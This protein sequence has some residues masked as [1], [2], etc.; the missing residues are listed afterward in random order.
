L[1]EACPTAREANIPVE[2][3]HLK[4]SGK[5]NGGQDEDVIAKIE[6]SAAQTDWT[7]LRTSIH[8]W[9]AQRRSVGFHSA[10]VA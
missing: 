10:E 3:F 6:Q 4:A 1:D 7:L 8:T 9:P 2:I 5:Q